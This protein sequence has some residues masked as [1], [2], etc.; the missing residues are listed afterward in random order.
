M[1]SPSVASPSSLTGASSEEVV[2]PII[3]IFSMSLALYLE[4]PSSDW[5]LT[6]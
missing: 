4:R 3:K 5:A 6:V 2:L 1:V